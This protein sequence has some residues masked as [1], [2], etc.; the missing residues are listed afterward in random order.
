MVALNIF[1]IL[2][3]AWSVAA[4]DVVTIN[5]YNKNGCSGTPDVKV[6]LYPAD[7]CVNLGLFSFKASCTTVTT[8]GDAD[9]KNV[10]GTNA[11]EL[12]ACAST[13]SFSTEYKCAP[14]DDSKLAKFS[15]GT[16][17]CVDGAPSGMVVDTFLVV[18]TCLRTATAPGAG[19]SEAVAGSYKLTVSGDTV[20]YSTW[21][22]LPDCSG[23][24]TATAKFTIGECTSGSA[25]GGSGGSSKMSPGVDGAKLS[26]SSASFVIVSYVA[27]FVSAIAAF[28][29]VSA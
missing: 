15:V 22:S 19:A 10:G 16:A 13:S 7:T 11:F 29:A 6:P 17:A 4:V 20:T 8:Y 3:L 9:C 26:S 27:M 25:N 18:G 1:S 21:A 14:V 2:A 28:M 12:N 24:A 23:S 5:T